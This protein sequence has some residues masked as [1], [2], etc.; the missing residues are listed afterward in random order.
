[1]KT[2]KS[3][4]FRNFKFE[5][6]ITLIYLIFGLLWILF[7]DTV[8]D[9]VEKDDSLL[10]QFQT[11][12]GAFFI[13]VTSLFLY[14]LV[15]RHMQNL[16]VAESQFSESEFRFNKLYENCPFGMVMANKDFKFIKANTAFCAI[17]GYSEAELKQYTFKD[18]SHPDDMVNDLHNIKKLTNKELT[19][20][21]TEKRYIR[22]DGQVIWGSLTVIANYDS[23][24]Q[25]LYNLGIIEDVTDRKHIENEFFE[26][27]LN[28]HRSIS[29][30]PVGIRIVSVDGKTIYTNKAFLDIYDFYNL[31][32]FTSTPAVNR[33]T[34]ESYIQHN[35]RKEQ[36]KKGNEILDYEIS[37]VCKNDKI[38]HVKVSRKEILWNGTKH[39]QVINI[40][41][42]EQRNAESELRK[43]SKAVEQSPV[44]I[45]IT[46]P[47]GMIEY[48]NPIVIQLTG[49]SADELINE[50][51]R[52]F[53]SGEKP[54]EEYTELWQIIKSGNIWSG[55]LH[56]KKKNGE[57]YW[58]ST[59]ISPIF[60]TSGQITHFLSIKEDIT[61]RKRA[62][63]ALNKSEEL[64]RKFASHLQN[65]R[66]EE[67]VALA[68]EIHDDL[69][70][71]LVAL[72]IDMG[73]L[74]K[75]VAIFNAYIDSQNILAKFDN[76]VN[77]I[78]R[79]IKTAR[80][81]M[82]GLRP[83]LLEMNGFITTAISYLAEFEDRHKISCKFISDISTIEMN[84]QQSLVFFRILQESLN[85]IA[86]HSKATS[87]KIH[88]RNESNK[89]ILEIIDNG[90]G[91][92]KNISGRKDSYGMIGMKERVVLL[93]GELD[94]ASEVDK[95]TCVCVEI[96]WNITQID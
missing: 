28:F 56:N 33:Y 6:R 63:I 58:E 79:T 41:I 1:M 25:F 7:S 29:E 61:D 59:T 17:M 96:P 93:K 69:G 9:L 94:I 95:G 8:L 67:K 37:I 75:D 15:K 64:L 60:D 3:N 43:L 13:L 85:N 16:R 35:E 55:E 2:H 73:L 86:K 53:G 4:L 26:S 48:V 46:D 70:Q 80:R 5:Y 52:I 82:N 44:A 65:V 91:F 74:K 42:T 57:L 47:D 36:R 10:T 31:E 34:A 84:S 49:F 90:I 51:T 14:L 89:L 22:K 12:K 30:S 40:D 88:F 71:T 81:I 92:D 11:Y 54:R 19:V 72:K 78:D 38:R 23:N 20:Y 76:I 87:V 68:R 39:F 50:N 27:Q 45:C 62:E 32:E 77:L 18:V 83:E 21:K 66:E 24:G